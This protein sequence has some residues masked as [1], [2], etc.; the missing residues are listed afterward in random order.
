MLVGWWDG[1]KAS[2]KG[3]S[4]WE[5]WEGRQS[6]MGVRAACASEGKGMAA[7]PGKAGGAGEGLL[8]LSLLVQGQELLRR[9]GGR[10]P[11]SSPGRRE[12]PSEDAGTDHDGSSSRHGSRQGGRRGLLALHG[13]GA[14]LADALQELQS[15]AEERG[16]RV[17]RQGTVAA[18]RDE[19]FECAAT[20]PAPGKAGKGSA[21]K[22]SF[23][24]ASC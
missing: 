18:G 1:G 19:V 21:H 11:A 23:R 22:T 12:G 5:L 17:R 10:Q 8:S 2:K 15:G 4:S 9:Q 3:R 20:G 13:A 6:R 16:G 7:G 14:L 24:V